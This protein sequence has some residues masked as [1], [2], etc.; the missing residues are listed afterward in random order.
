M[1][2]PAAPTS[3]V[4]PCGMNGSSASLVAETTSTV[5][6]RQ[7]TFDT[8]VENCD[9]VVSFAPQLDVVVLDQENLSVP[10]SASERSNTPVPA[11]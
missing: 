9:D 10:S 6:V 2:Q 3:L 4:D 11:P 1:L 5:Q 8:P 7:V